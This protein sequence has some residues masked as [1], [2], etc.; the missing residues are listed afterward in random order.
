MSASEY[1]EVDAKNYV[2]EGRPSLRY[3][4]DL[5][6]LLKQIRCDIAVRYSDGHL[7]A[8]MIWSSRMTTKLIDEITSTLSI[9]FGNIERVEI[10]YGYRITLEVAYRPDGTEIARRA[11]QEKKVCASETERTAKSASVTTPPKV[12][13]MAT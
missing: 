8:F 9:W 11:R 10:I 6:R 1:E 12:P 4:T 3:N 2:T 5:S 13:R 7:P